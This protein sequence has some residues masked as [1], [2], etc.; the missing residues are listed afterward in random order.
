MSSDRAAM[1]ER[2]RAG[3][4]ARAL[5]IEKLLESEG[6][7]ARRE[8]LGELHTLKGEGRMLGL[9]LLADLAHTLEGWLGQ[10]G[11]SAGALRGLDAMQKAL[12]SGVPPE[13]ADAVLEAALL[14]LGYVPENE[15]SA[16][17]EAAG[18]SESAPADAA[19]SEARRYVQVDAATVDDL[20]ERLS[21]LGALYGRL[22]G[23][24]LALLA[25]SSDQARAHSALGEDFARVSAVVADTTTR[26]WKLRLVPIEPV[27]RELR[28]HARVLAEETGKNL[29]VRI[30]TRGVEL[31]RN[32]LDQ[33]WDSLLHLVHNAVDHGLET[34]EER[35]EKPAVATLTLS[36]EA[37]GPH[38][39]LRVDDDGRG[40][41]TAELRESWA[42][43]GR[44]A[45]PAHATDD[46]V[47]ELLFEHGFSTRTEVSTVSGRGVGLAV[48]KRQVE[49]LGGRVRIESELGRGTRFELT[50]PFTITKERC[51][52]VELGPALYAF[53]ARSVVAVLGT[54]ELPAGGAQ[55]HLVR[56]RGEGIPLV[57][58]AAA[59][60]LAVG[61]PDTAAVVLD[62][63]GRKY[64]LGVPVVQ[65]D[66]E[67]IRRPAEALLGNLTGIAATALLDD[68]R[69][70]LMLDGPFLKRALNDPGRRSVAPPS[71]HAGSRAKRVLVADDSPVV[72][73]VVREIL[74]S[75]GY[76]V[77]LT[78][79]GT[80]ALAAFRRREPDLVLSDLEMPQ[81]GGFELLA[82]IRRLSQNVP[83]VMLTTRGSL[84][85]RQ[86]A[87]ELGAN[88]YL[89]KTG[90]KSDSLLDVVRRFVPGRPA[91]LPAFAR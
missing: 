81:M 78:H 47:L 48:V 29:A 65:G 31:E 77:E 64:A 85:D 39:V 71:P 88:A 8:A 23:R 37:V 46:Q 10:G 24:T 40:I 5:R 34:P 56:Y 86:R 67:L 83:V 35:G 49:R 60:G 73:Q 45:A 69:L 62:L 51:L 2:F 72:C 38:V 53:P 22:R 14:E 9:S 17:P 91:A 50:V 44:L 41:D 87:T 36:A 68:G 55:A 61:A 27:L 79:D 80:E 20:C 28:R 63:S 7:E 75:A 74:T 59:L 84:E 4:L 70:V 57:S 52:I 3:L 12:S 30:E 82:E 11:T 26:A 6:D 89:L 21:E 76:E 42:R 25:A 16:A 90:F 1:L 54:H 19:R 18:S 32:V 66:P 13:I 33:L 15:A 58:L 43:A